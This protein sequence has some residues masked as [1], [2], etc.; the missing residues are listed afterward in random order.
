MSL[1]GALS[2]HPERSAAKS[3]DAAIPWRTETVCG[4]S[5]IATA[6]Y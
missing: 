1:R 5:G 4:R 2:G 3:K 6:S